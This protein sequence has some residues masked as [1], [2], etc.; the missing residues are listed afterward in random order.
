[1]SRAPSL[2]RPCFQP[3]LEALEDRLVPARQ[4]LPTL[5]TPPA[6]ATDHILV[7][8]QPDSTPHTIAGTRLG[9]ELP[10]VDG[11]YEVELRGGQKVNTVVNAYRH[12]PGVLYAEPDYIVR[13][14]A[15]PNDTSFGSQWQMNN[16]GQTFGK[17]DADID[18]PEAW[19]IT[20]GN[21]SSIVAVIDTGVDY[22]HPDLAANI[23]T[24]PGEIAGNGIDDD[25]NGYI[26]DVH[27]WDFANNDND[28]MD[29]Y[30][31]G[32]HVAGIL[33]AVGGNGKGVAGTMWHVQIMP[34]KF[35]A[36]NG[37]GTVSDAIRALDYAVL[38]GAKVSN[39]SWGRADN[40]PAFVDALERARIN[41]HIFV[42]AAGNNVRNLD[43]QPVYPAS[44]NVD[45]V[46]AVASVDKNGKLATT[47]NW[48]VNTVDL[49]APGD[50]VY[51]TLPGNRYGSMSGTSMASP[52]VTGAAALL[53]EQ[54]PDWTY[55][56]VIDRLKQTVDHR[57][58]LAGKVSSGGIL[59][60]ARALRDD[61][62]TETGPRVAS[63]TTFNT[64]TVSK[65]RVTF[66]DTL[67]PIQ[68][69]TFTAA[70]IKL[71]KPNGTAITITSVATVTGSKYMQFDITFAAQT[72][73]GTYRVEVGPTIL[74][75][76]G[77]AMNQ[78]GDDQYGEA[79]DDKFIGTF[80]VNQV[81]TLS[82]TVPMPLPDQQTRISTITI[83]QDIAIAD[84]RVR[85]NLG[86]T[87]DSNLC[88]HLLAPDG[89]DILLAN[90][91]GGSGDNFT[92]TVFSDAA[93]TSIGSGYAPYS[94][95]YRP[96][97]PLAAVDGK[98]ARGTW[99][100][101]IEDRAAGNAG[102]LNSWSL[103]VEG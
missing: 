19:D 97:T 84:L 28:P 36:A 27:G 14:S 73:P 98:N 45:N 95:T 101:V 99:Q 102:T 34:L 58:E 21:G 30:G 62:T 8:F 29:D 96:E 12:L 1:M 68:P 42:T 25:G 100:L 32:T 54:H 79:I 40:D 92:G 53:Y 31:H 87:Y 103:L 74:D 5:P 46:V 86:H 56:Q 43:Q 50:N 33:G 44:Y 39:N 80:K 15:I 72:V 13:P 41:G 6:F 89:T 16:T 2:R 49:A 51:S 37:V 22:T 64:L 67:D 85:L 93:G 76:T 20:T 66:A 57:P 75:S 23:W 35:I 88:I 78:D 77:L 24:N 10:M 82:N 18:A 9:A 7:R 71:Y 3:A 38:M 94:S 90:R 4:I 81:F 11:L 47:S 83:D 55:Q 60:L 17:Y 48:G 26:D 52:L 69:A 91:R 61:L 70:D 63:I 65:L 59:N